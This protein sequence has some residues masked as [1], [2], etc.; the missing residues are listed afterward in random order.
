[1]A[2]HHRCDAWLYLRWPSDYGWLSDA[3]FDCPLSLHLLTTSSGGKWHIGFPVAS[4]FVWGMRGYAFPAFNRVVLDT[5][6]WATESWLG[7]MCVRATVGSIWP[8]FY[9]IK[10]TF[11]D[12]LPMT[13]GDFV[14]WLLFVLLAAA[15]VM[16]R[17]EKFHWPGIVIMAT[18]FVT[19]LALVGWFSHKAG[20][21]GVLFTSTESLTGVTPASGSAF[22][23][24]FVHGL[25]TMISSQATGLLGFADWGRYAKHPGAQRWPQGLGMALSDMFSAILGIICASCCATIYPD[26]GLVWNQALLLTEIQKHE[27]PAARAAVFFASI[28]ILLAQLFITVTG[29]SI[30]AGSKS[31]KCLYSLKPTDWLVVDLSGLA[32]KYLNLRRAGFIVVIVG[33]CKLGLE[34]EHPSY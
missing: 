21:V 15:G 1:M 12:S 16:L 13:T 14:A 17:P 8:S 24:A 5:V 28:P 31:T 10:N 18:N 26:A 29:S 25:T 30:A 34:S 22:G 3:R 27:E 2:V 20:G 6:W 33:I 9:N 7:M 4:R 23:W 19:V 32:P 11:P